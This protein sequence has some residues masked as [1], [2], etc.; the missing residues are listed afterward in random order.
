MCRVFKKKNLFKVCG[1]TNEAGSGGGNSS[2]ASATN[3]YDIN[4]ITNNS[5]HHMINA[6]NYHQVILSKNS[7]NGINIQQANQYYNLSRQPA[8]ANQI[9][10]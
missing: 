4:I 10:I 2:T 6:C 1:A 8:I 3:N 9:S 5:D 7:A